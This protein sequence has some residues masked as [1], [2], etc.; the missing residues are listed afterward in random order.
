MDQLFTKRNFSERP[1]RGS[2]SPKFGWPLLAVTCWPHWLGLGLLSSQ[3]LLL[4]HTWRDK[5]AARIGKQLAKGRWPRRVPANLRRCFPQM[6][7]Q[8]IDAI[9]LEYCQTQACIIMDL[10]SLWLSSEKQLQKRV[11]FSGLEH[12]E[13]P[14]AESRPVCLLVCHSMGMEHA[15]HILKKSFPLL[16]YYQSFGS[17]VVDWFFYRLRA[18]NG[19]YLLQRG[20][21][22]R[23]L[24]RDM[25]DGWMLYMMIDEDMGEREGH[26]TAFYATE[27]CAIKAPAKLA[28]ITS[29]AAVPVYSWYNREEHCYEVKILPALQDFPT[30]DEPSD[31]AQLMSSLET[32][33]DINPGQYGWRQQLFRSER[34][35][36]N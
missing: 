14:F 20:D 10:P 18:R 7:D 12:L 35:R 16:G 11:R 27:K 26:W 4:P 29:A 15:A 25:R 36:T 13:T 17:A 8:E 33:I 31:V 23:Q 30:D 6:S 21:S 1:H 28:A 22:M 24:V 5:L 19:G 34:H 9:V 3:W 32:M 2:E